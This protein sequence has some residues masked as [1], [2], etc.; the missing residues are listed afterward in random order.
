MARIQ[1]PELPLP[2]TRR[3]AVLA[4]IVSLALADAV[5]AA[6]LW[7]LWQDKHGPAPHSG[8]RSLAP[9]GSNHTPANAAEP[10]A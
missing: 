1:L 4:L 2:M 8:Q 3:R 7:M 5:G 9:A 10:K 6:M